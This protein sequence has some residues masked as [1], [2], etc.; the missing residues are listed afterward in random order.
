MQPQF[1]EALAARLV[2]LLSQPFDLDG[3]QAVIGVS[4][5]I[6]IATAEKGIVSPEVML[7]QGDM[8]L[9]SAKAAGRNAFR[10]FHQEMNDSLTHRK[11]LEADLR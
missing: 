11:E 5:G 2:G 3:H 10:F 6:A 4:I 7:Q 9:Y 1:A 8:A